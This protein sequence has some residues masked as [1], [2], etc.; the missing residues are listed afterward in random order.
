MWYVVQAA[1]GQE[2]KAVEQCRNA[3]PAAVYGELFS[4]GYEYMWRHQGTWHMKLGVLFPGY[5][6]IGSEKPEELEKSLE[7]IPGVVS[8]VCIGGGFYPIRKEEEDFL[9]SLFDE[10][11]CIRFS[12]GYIVD[13]KLIVEEGPL[14]GKSQ[15][16]TKIDRHKR[17]ADITLRLFEQERKVRL[18]LE[19]PAKLTSGEYRRMKETA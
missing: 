13:G 17:F 2:D 5:I 19:V 14:C 9:Q 15:Y 3:I 8:P 18:G 1:A 4:P 11:Y 12:T 7:H 6:F 16:V 10:T